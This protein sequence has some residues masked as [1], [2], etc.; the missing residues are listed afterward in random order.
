MAAL[1]EYGQEEYGISGFPTPTFAFEV[2]NDYKI[3][4]SQI[5]MTNEKS[6][7]KDQN[8]SSP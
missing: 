8:D 3:D 6:I 4:A 5:N 7:A 2:I 1:Y